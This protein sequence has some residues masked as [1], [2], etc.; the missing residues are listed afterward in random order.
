MLKLCK[1]LS[2]TLCNKN[3]YCFIPISVIR[4][5]HSFTNI[6]IKLH[7]NDQE[8][9]TIQKETFTLLRKQIK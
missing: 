3:H 8:H 9:N 6:T 2:Q 7:V 1:K 4:H 5:Q